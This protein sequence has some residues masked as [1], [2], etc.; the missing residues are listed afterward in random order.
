MEKFKTSFNAGIKYQ[1]FTQDG[2]NFRVTSLDNKKGATPAAS[3]LNGGEN[4]LYLL[5]AEVELPPKT[6]LTFGSGFIS[7]N[8]FRTDKLKNNVTG[9]KDFNKLLH[10]LHQLH[11]KLNLV[12]EVVYL[13]KD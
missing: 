5:Q 9:N 6:I 12:Q 2:Q 1:S 10:V 7:Y 3:V 8:Y 11:S 4:T 13:R